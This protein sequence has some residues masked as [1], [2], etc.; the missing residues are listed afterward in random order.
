MAKIIET[1][2][3][4][5]DDGKIDGVQSRLIEVESW[6]SYVDEIKDGKSIMRTSLI[7]NLTGYSLPK[8][9]VVEQLKYDKNTLSFYFYNP[10]G[11]FN[12]SLRSKMVRL[13]YLIEE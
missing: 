3:S 12:S 10:L 8:N 7:G 1:N 13:A 5:A 4:L 9:V 11:Y 2:V 6:E